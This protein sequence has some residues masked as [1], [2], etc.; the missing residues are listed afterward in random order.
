MAAALGILCVALPA[1]ARPTLPHACAIPKRL[2]ASLPRAAA[3]YS[4]AEAERTALSNQI[5]SFESQCGGQIIEGSP[6]HATCIG[7][8]RAVN[9]NTDAYL[10]LLRDNQAALKADLSLL[11]SE[12]TMRVAT[13]D[14]QIAATRAKLAAEGD[15]IRGIEAAAKEWEDVAESAR[16]DMQSK[17]WVTLRDAF[18]D[19]SIKRIMAR[20]EAEIALDQKQIRNVNRAV[21]DLALPMGKKVLS[22]AELDKLLWWNSYFTAHGWKFGLRLSE[23][24]SSVVVLK[25]LKE[26]NALVDRV[27]AVNAWDN[28]ASRE[29][30]LKAYA[31][32]LK[33]ALNS[34]HAKLIVN[35]WDVNFSL[36]YLFVA[37]NE[38]MARVDQL[39]QISI[40]SLKG[41][42]SISARH[43]RL[44]DNRAALKQLQ[45]SA[46][47]NGADG[48]PL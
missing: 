27:D 4:Q 44:V 18:L 46:D 29:N 36:A 23:N 8:D 22:K 6:Q 47:A 42:E 11:R 7:V 35:Q 20:R 48:C 2:E 1:A 13:L 31:A 24:K 32:T 19:Y 21:S 45:Q 10:G 14:T 26:F 17:A 40:D 38:A 33:A 37:E 28:D 25:A 34:P 41:I 39:H 43:K 30:M 12:A 16:L 9:A 5:A 15:R 3:R